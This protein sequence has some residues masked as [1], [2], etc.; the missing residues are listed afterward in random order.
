MHSIVHRLPWA[1]AHFRSSKN[2]KYDKYG[3]FKQFAH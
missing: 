1:A 3:D 2:A